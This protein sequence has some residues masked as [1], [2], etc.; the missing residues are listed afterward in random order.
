MRYDTVSEFSE[1]YEHC[2]NMGELS[3]LLDDLYVY[4]NKDTGTI[5]AYD[6]E[7]DYQYT[8][9]PWV[10]PSGRCPMVAFPSLEPT[11]YER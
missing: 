3:W 6:S 5:E 9:L 1:H 10:A 8:L 4:L 11:F 7:L 2:Y